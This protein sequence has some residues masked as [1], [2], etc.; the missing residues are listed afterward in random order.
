MWIETVQMFWLEFQNFPE[1]SSLS[2]AEPAKDWTHVIPKQQGDFS[3]YIALWIGQMTTFVKHPSF[4]MIAQRTMKDKFSSLS[5][6][7]TCWDNNSL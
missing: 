1:A 5:E 6:K 3:I 7:A 2:R 4:S